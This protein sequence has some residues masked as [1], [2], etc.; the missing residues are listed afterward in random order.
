LSCVTT[1]LAVLLALGLRENRRALATGMGFS[2]GTMVLLSLL[3]LLP[4]SIAGAGIR[5]ALVSAG[6]GVAVIWAAVLV[7]PHTPLVEERGETRD[8]SGTTSVYLVV[9]GLILH[10]IPEGFAMANAYI[11]SPGLGILIALAIALH[12]LPE[13]FAMAVPAVTLRSRRRRFGTVLLAALAEPVGAIIGLAAVGIAPALNAGFLAFAAGAMLFVAAHG[14][15]PMARRYRHPGLFLGGLG[16]AALVYRLLA[17][18]ILGSA[19]P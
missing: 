11:A 13:Q 7:V 8:T 2:T 3:E 15:I 1:T 14:L 10:D 16:L 6:L 19:G 9:C 17:G 12:N 5:G 4:A 18:A